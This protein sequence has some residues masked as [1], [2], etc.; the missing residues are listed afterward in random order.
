MCPGS[1]WSQWFESLRDSVFN[2]R[3]CLWLWCIHF[4]LVSSSVKWECK[5]LTSIREP[6]EKPLRLFRCVRPKYRPP[7]T[8]Y[9]TGSPLSCVPQQ[10]LSVACRAHPGIGNTSLEM[11][12][13]G[14]GISLMWISWVLQREALSILPSRWLIF[15]P[16]TREAH[17]L[18]LECLKEKSI[19]PEEPPSKK[20]GSNS[21]PGLVVMLSKSAFQAGKI[22]HCYGWMS[23]SL[24]Q[25]LL[26]WSPNLQCDCI[27]K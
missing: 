9:L 20:S 18:L 8:L 19:V 1:G 10:W 17:H 15:C 3:L 25:I 14:C 22:S 5:S 16:H 21:L 23:V 11:Y 2:H 27:W 24:T 4:F 6:P 12:V 26:R 7:G 13:G